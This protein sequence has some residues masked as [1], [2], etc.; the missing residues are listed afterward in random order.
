MWHIGQELC[1]SCLAFCPEHI[2]CA[3]REVIRRIV[4]ST[5]TSSTRRPRWRV[6]ALVSLLDE[7][8]NISLRD[9]SHSRGPAGL[10]RNRIGYTVYGFERSP[11]TRL[12][13]R[14]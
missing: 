9:Q 10:K 4:R 1:S 12:R 11:C 6:R 3:G 14:K 2:D 8:L 5:S 13:G 7:R